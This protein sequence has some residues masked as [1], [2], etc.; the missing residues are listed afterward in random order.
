MAN[1]T[2]QGVVLKE[3][4]KVV[5]VGNS[6]GVLIPASM[7]DEMQLQ[8]GDEVTVECVNGEIVVKK[9]KSE[10]PAGLSP[11]FLD[12]LGEC[13]TEYDETMKQLVDK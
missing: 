1:E 8:K 7:L 5:K 12:V 2:T 13:L 10:L 6:H 3:E 4:R 9:K 11:D